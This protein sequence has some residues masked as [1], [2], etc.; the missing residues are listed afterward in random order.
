MVLWPS[1]SL[2]A[3][4]PYDAASPLA[5]RLRV[6]VRMD[7]MNAAEAALRRGDERGLP[8][9]APGPSGAE[10]YEQVARGAVEAIIEPG[11]A[12]FFPADWAHHIESRGDL[13]VALSLREVDGVARGDLILAWPLHYG[14]GGK[15]VLL[16]HD[17]HGPG[18]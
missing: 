14:G 16:R 2:E 17:E 13:S 8:D 4:R 7:G 1:T 15:R 5:R 11:D 10:A 18:G 6:D 12:L 3:L 9:G